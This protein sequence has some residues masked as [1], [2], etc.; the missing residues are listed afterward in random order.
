MDTQAKKLPREKIV[1]ESL[2]KSF[3]IKVSS[4]SQALC[5]S[6]KYAPEHL[7]VNTKVCN[8]TGH[9]NRSYISSPKCV[10]EQ[11]CMY[12]FIYPRVDEAV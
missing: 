1:R 2:S 6:N 7:I 3:V 12:N 10:K 11:N 8:I 9:L 4:M 5:F